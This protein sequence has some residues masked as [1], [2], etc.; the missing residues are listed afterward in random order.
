MSV[1]NLK[2]ENLNPF[3]IAQH[4]FDQAADRLKLDAGMRLSLIH[5]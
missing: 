3:D 5:I 4:Y 1:A 2:A